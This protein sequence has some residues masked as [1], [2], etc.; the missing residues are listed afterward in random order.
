MTEPAPTAD[1]CQHCPACAD[2]VTWLEGQLLSAVDSYSSLTRLLGMQVQVA[3]SA[4]LMAE[5]LGR[6]RD[7]VNERRLRQIERHL[8]EGEPPPS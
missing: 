4:N 8:S 7:T 6:S 1:G 2:Y 3:E 5:L